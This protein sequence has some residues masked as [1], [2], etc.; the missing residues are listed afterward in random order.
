MQSHAHTFYAMASDCRVLIEGAGVEAA[1]AGAA[2]VE[3]EVHRIEAR[4]SRFRKDSELSRINHIAAAG[5]ETRIDAETAAL[6]AFAQ[7]L[8][9]KSGGVFDITTGLLRRAWNFDRAEIPPPSEIEAL[10]SRIGLEKLVLEGDHLTF[11]QVGMELD[12]GGLGKEFAVDRGVEVLAEL[13]LNHCLVDLGG[14]IRV[15]GPRE[16]GSPWRIGVRDPAA[17][18]NA[19][20]C[21]DLASGALATSGD[22][23]RNIVVR[24]H[25]YGHILDPRTGWPAQGLTSASVVA[26]TCL[27]AGGVASA[28]LAMG[29][30][31]TEWLAALG[32]P[33]LAIDAAMGLRQEGFSVSGPDQ[34]AILT[35]LPGE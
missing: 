31:G 14:D 32:L 12:F 1:R 23:L 28:A 17:P 18:Q 16:D 5:G 4:Y 24:G 6:I 8:F 7:A 34:I 2:A 35:D 29:E 3:D 13:G 22:Y 15:T 11:T 20:A 26:P 19:I 25:R 10:K 33:Y 27:V 21:Y 9:A 30:A